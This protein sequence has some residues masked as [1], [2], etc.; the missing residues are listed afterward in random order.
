MTNLGISTADLAHPLNQ[1]TN[2]VERYGIN[3]VHSAG[4][5]LLGGPQ[6]VVG[7]QRGAV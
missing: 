2:L 3:D 1:Q 5:A 6:R 7:Q 4:I